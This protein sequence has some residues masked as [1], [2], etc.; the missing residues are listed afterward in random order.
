MGAHYPEVMSIE[1]AESA[2]LRAAI[3]A[4]RDALAGI[5]ERYQAANPR[6][7]GSVARGDATSESDI[8]LLVDLLPDGGNEL[9]RVAGIAEELSVLLGKRVDVVAAPLMRDEVSASALADSVTV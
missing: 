7:F 9:L 3:T 6:L 1:T 4:H 8:D 5:L 2:S